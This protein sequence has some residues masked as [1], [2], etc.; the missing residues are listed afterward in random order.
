MNTNQ[1]LNA[2][3]QSEDQRLLENVAGTPIVD[4]NLLRQIGGGMSN[5]SSGFICTISG[6]CN[7]SGRSCWPF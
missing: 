5:R 4:E 6:E 3:K 7:G 2:W 1:I